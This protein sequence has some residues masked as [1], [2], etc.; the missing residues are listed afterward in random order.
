MPFIELPAKPP[1]TD[2]QRLY[3]I[4]ISLAHAESDLHLPIAEEGL[5]FRER[6][7]RI[8]K[9]ASGSRRIAPHLFQLSRLIAHT[10]AFAGTEEERREQPE[11]G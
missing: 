6:A 11:D 10:P 3:G 7:E 9:H 4:L 2:E 5:S 8:L 1:F